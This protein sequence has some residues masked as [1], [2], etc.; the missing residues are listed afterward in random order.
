MAISFELSK[1]SVNGHNEILIK[2]LYRYNGK[3]TTARAK[4]GVTVISDWFNY[5]VGDTK[6]SPLKN[7]RL[8]TPE[9]EKAQTYHE[10][11]KITF[12]ELTAAIAEAEKTADKGNSDWLRLVVDKKNNPD[13]YIPKEKKVKKTPTLLEY[14]DE[15]IKE[16][17]TRIHETTTLK[18]SENSIK[19]YRT[20][21]KHLTDF[22]ETQNRADY[23]FEEID[24]QF[25]TDFVKYL[26]NKSF[27]V[28]SIGKY[29]K[30]LRAILYRATDEKHYYSSDKK[31][32]Y[33]SPKETDVDTVYFSETELMRLKNTDLSKIPY[34]ERVRDMFLLLCWTGCRFSDLPKIC[35]E[36]IK[37]NR[38]EIRQQKTTAR[39]I[40]PILPVTKEILEKYNYQ[41]H[42]ISNPDFNRF[43]KE[44]CR[45]A[46]FD[47]AVKI[48]RTIKGKMEEFTYKKYELVTSHT[49]RRSFCTNMYEKGM[50]T[51]M[52]MSVSGHKSLDIFLHYIKT[53]REKHADRMSEQW[54]KCLKQ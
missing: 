51:T 27:K 17:P 33:Q 25:Y 22:C 14:A 53:T 35:S 48:T 16:Y 24:K 47:E 42:I 7:K 12:A 30:A 31:V 43:I 40:I 8:I 19:P 26:Q 52:I 1:K 2:C 29:V 18:F 5:V 4:S 20:L 15:F 28:S 6:D 41:P 34:L 39:V 3:V 54:E 10:K 36:N 32:K 49:G 9:M 23:K 13:K 38:I 11:Q 37:D 50:D 45:K 44:A 46:G 21:V